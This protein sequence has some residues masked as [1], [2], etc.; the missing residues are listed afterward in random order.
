MVDVFDGGL[1]GLV[2]IDGIHQFQGRR[3][4]GFSERENARKRSSSD[5]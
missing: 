1:G 2:Y 4:S 3:S 5:V